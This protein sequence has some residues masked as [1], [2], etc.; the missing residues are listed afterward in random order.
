MSNPQYI[1]VSVD[2]VW[3]SKL[4]GGTVTVEA[5]GSRFQLPTTMSK[6]T[7][8]L[9]SDPSIQYVVYRRGTGTLSVMTVYQFIKKYKEVPT[10][11]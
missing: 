3:K 4:T 10:N 9:S 7:D 5:V 8:R 1:V 6:I 2:S 11:E